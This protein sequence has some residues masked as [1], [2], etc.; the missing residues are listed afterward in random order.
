MFIPQC[1]KYL[2][3]QHHQP[4]QPHHHHHFHYQLLPRLLSKIDSRGF[5]GFT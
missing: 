3:L 2:N 4:Q 5:N 1:R